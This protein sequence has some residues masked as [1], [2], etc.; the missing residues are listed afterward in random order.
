MGGL[1]RLPWAEVS[2]ETTLR[3]LKMVEV[4]SLPDT[5]KEAG[6]GD[7][8]LPGGASSVLGGC[9]DPHP[10]C[11]AGSPVLHKCCGGSRG[12]VCS[13]RNPL[14]AAYGSAFTQPMCA[15]APFSPYAASLFPY[16]HKPL[17]LEQRKQ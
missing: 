10:V 16:Q 17:A 7:C 4:S 13:S 12:V 5:G 11:S 6:S 2:L 9:V 8:P 15:S 3:W 14:I 1:C